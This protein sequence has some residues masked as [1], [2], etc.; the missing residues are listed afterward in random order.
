MK[1]LRATAGVRGVQRLRMCRARKE[2]SCVECET[3]ANRKKGVGMNS[4]SGDTERTAMTAQTYQD[5][6]QPLCG[7]SLGIDGVPLCS[8]GTEPCLDSTILRGK[9]GGCGRR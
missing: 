5:K 6:L 4:Q 3:C 8:F 1:R 7:I 2:A 9:R